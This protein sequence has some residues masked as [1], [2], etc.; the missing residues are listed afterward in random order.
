MKTPLLILLLIAIPLHAQPFK[1]DWSNVLPPDKTNFFAQNSNLLNASVNT[2]GFGGGGFAASNGVFQGHLIFSTNGFA[3]HLTNGA[4]TN[5][6]I[7]CYLGSPTDSACDV[8]LT[9][10]GF[11]GWAY[12]PDGFAQVLFTNYYSAPFKPGCPPVVSVTLG[13]YGFADDFYANRGLFP[14]PWC[15]HNLSTTN[16]AVICGP[17]GVP[18]IGVAA[19]ETNWIF[20]LQILGNQ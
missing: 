4:C 9:N 2:N 18:A 5:G 1:L 20:H 12:T 15:D 8:A 13:N 3:G 10:L 6:Q 19:R 11:Y 14:Q 7:G 16:Y 17:Y